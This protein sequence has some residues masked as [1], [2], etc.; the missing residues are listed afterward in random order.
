M[1]KQKNRLTKHKDFTKAFK[2]GKSD[3]GKLLGIKV[4]KNELAESRFSIVA[5][6]KVSKKAVERNRAK[7][8]IRE[9]FTKQLESLKSGYDLVVICLPGIVGEDSTAIK[10]E[11]DKI[12]NNLKLYK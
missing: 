8:Q 5:G 1:F 4:L 9:I 12:L 2:Q 6:L 7:R 3:Y 10:K 11:V